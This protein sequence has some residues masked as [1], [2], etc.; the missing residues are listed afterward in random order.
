M[1]S[2]VPF[3][4]LLPLAVLLTPACTVVRVDS[5]SGPP[6]IGVDGLIEGHIAVGLPAE[7]RFIY[8]ELFDGRSRGALGEIVL[9]KLFRVEVGLAG[10]AIGLGPFD[11]A[12][13]A[14]AY[15]PRMPEL[16]SSEDEVEEYDAGGV[17]AE[18]A[19]APR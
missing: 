5:G 4:F 1:K 3:L 13:G 15:K 18:E 6:H 11:V 10:A 12:L 17:C 9:W 19:S 16:Q 7:D 2:L 14:L 8:A